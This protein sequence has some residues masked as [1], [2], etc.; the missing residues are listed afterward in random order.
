MEELKTN[1]LMQMNALEELRNEA[2]SSS[3]LYKEKTKRWHDQRIKSKDIH[4]GQK[5][6]LFNS[7]LKLFS[8]KLKSR[9]DGPFLVKTVFPH[10]AIE[11]IS[12]D[13]TPFK[14]NGHR[15]K[16][17]EEGVPRNE[18]LEE[19]LLCGIANT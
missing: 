2:Y 15:V 8:G 1:R 13:G 14:V 6:L 11:L 4:E 10:G 9:W 18:G 17:Y 5:V 16:K 19:L 12:R 7:R 3:W